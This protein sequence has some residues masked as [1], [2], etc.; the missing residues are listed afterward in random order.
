MK[1]CKQCIYRMMF[2]IIELI[3]TNCVRRVARKV[4]KTKYPIQRIVLKKNWDLFETK[5]WRYCVKC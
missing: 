3:A 4:M 5:I 2:V 1:Q